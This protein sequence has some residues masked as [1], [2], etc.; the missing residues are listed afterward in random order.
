MAQVPN[1]PAAPT[2]AESGAPIG[3]SPPAGAF[4]A[5]T[6][7]QAGKELGTTLASGGDMLEKHALAMAALTNKAMSDEATMAMATEQQQYVEKFKT[8]NPGFLAQQNFGQAQK[9]LSAI[10][11]KYRGQVTDPMA[12]SMFDMDSRRMSYFANSQ[13]TQFTAQS[14]REAIVKSDNSREMLDIQ[15]GIAGFADPDVRARTMDT[16]AKHGQFR[17]AAEGTDDNT[18]DLD[19]LTRQSMYM[20]DGLGQMALTD[21]AGARKI[22]AQELAA[23][24]I[25]PNDARELDQYIHRAE[26]PQKVDAW[27]QGELSG[28]T[29]AG[30]VPGSLAGLFAHQ[31]SGAN[32]N[33]HPSVDGA[34]GQFQITPGTFAK[35]A[36]PGENIDNP[37]DNAAVG[38]RILDHYNT[39]FHGDLGRVATAY[40]S[41]EANVAPAGSAT[42][43]L[44][45]AVDGN[46]KS[47]SSY[48]ADIQ[49]R[50]GPPNMN[51]PQGVDQWEAQTLAK[52][53]QQFTDPVEREL[54]ERTVAAEAGRR[55][56][57]V[58][59]NSE[60]VRGGF[61]LAIAGG[62][63]G[64]KVPTSMTELAQMYP[65]VYQQL[66]ALTPGEYASVVNGVKANA[67]GRMVNFG[68]EA[69]ANYQS[70]LTESR[71]NPGTFASRDL[72]T[73]PMMAQVPAQ[74]RNQLLKDQAMIR[75]GK[76]PE[77]YV[78]RAFNAAAPW[79]N[80]AFPAKSMTAANTPDLL[81]LQTALANDVREYVSVNKKAPDDAW[82][83]QKVRSLL[84]GKAYDNPGANGLIPGVPNDWLQSAAAMAHAAGHYG[85]TNQQYVQWFQR[86]RAAHAQP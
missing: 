82:V 14:Q 72:L 16:L 59:N 20:K 46:G 17:Q 8:Q 62:P 33:I 27:V 47:V 32:P 67:E 69:Q 48:V 74:M 71:A 24:H 1:T 80:Q 53:D 79:I 78:S 12:Q 76:D 54:A 2:V 73:D 25:A 57:L 60:Q 9:D 3:I 39:E 34:R 6:L 64:S 61:A 58:T 45:D 52:A 37:K 50:A 38:A 7:G 15:H 41:G 42:P 18:R 84:V 29:V 21:A 44:H 56:S 63:D 65:Q 35:F 85:L 10:R 51:S 30:Q 81:N 5:N 55:R 49:A 11:D 19:V 40:F 75:G 26:A 28:A 43:W 22:F 70:L 4:G 66:G 68:P 13:I 86:E 31:E 23:G 36:R 83:Q 77:P